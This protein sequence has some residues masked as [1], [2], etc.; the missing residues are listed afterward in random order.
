MW[1]AR[2]YSCLKLRLQNGHLYTTQSPENHKGLN[3]QVC[4]LGFYMDRGVLL[5]VLLSRVKA[6]SV[7]DA[8]K[9]LDA[10]SCLSDEELYMLAKHLFPELQL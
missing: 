7:E 6:E 2:A 1:I 10:L 8:I 4:F 3:K 9:L 5:E